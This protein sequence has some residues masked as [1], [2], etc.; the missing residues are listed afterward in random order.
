MLEF[1]FLGAHLVWMMAADDM[2]F[3][4]DA[5]TI[6]PADAIGV[7][8]HR[9]EVGNVANLV[10]LE[11]ETIAEALRFH[12][13]PRAVVSHGMLVDRVALKAAAAVPA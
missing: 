2:E 13:A 3:L 5:I 7:D 6:N 8:N 11:G 1:A 12:A 4:Y 9:L 10:V